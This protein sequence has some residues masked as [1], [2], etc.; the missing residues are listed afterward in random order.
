M[1]PIGQNT[2]RR[3][4]ITQLDPQQVQAKNAAKSPFIFRN[5]LNQDFQTVMRNFGTGPVRP[6]FQELAQVNF[7]AGP[8]KFCIKISHSVCHTLIWS[9]P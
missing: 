8:R 6:R 7:E 9:G 2:K 3:D 5:N 1:T 4:I